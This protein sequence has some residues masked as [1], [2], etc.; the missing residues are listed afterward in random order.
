MEIDNEKCIYKKEIYFDRY[1]LGTVQHGLLPSELNKEQQKFL[2]KKF[3]SAIPTILSEIRGFKADIVLLEKNSFIYKSLSIELNKISIINGIFLPSRLSN[4]LMYFEQG[5]LDKPFYF[6]IP[7]KNDIFQSRVDYLKT[8]RTDKGIVSYLKNRFKNTQ[9]FDDRILALKRSGRSKT[10]GW[11]LRW[12]AKHE[13]DKVSVVPGKGVYIFLQ[14]QP[15][16]A[17]EDCNEDWHDQISRIVE[18]RRL[19]PG[20]VPVYIKESPSMVYRRD[21]ESYSRLNRIP[22]TF[23]LERKASFTQIIQNA[24]C[25]ITFSGTIAI[26]GVVRGVPTVIFHSTWFHEAPGITKFNSLSDFIFEKIPER[27][28]VREN[29]AFFKKIANN[30]CVEGR[31]LFLARPNPTRRD[32]ENYGDAIIEIIKRG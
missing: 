6:N 10:I 15:E 4:N 31:T 25:I 3:V 2:I 20:E 11:L 7:V 26:E 28:D 21:L 23:L 17:L 13:F 29:L 12:V 24:K 5:K 32:F 30:I 8:H 16:L 1:I 27:T 9:K 22:N 19:I 18:L 14:H